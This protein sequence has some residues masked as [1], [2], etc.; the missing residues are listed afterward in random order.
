M[1]GM[2]EVNISVQLFVHGFVSCEHPRRTGFATPSETFKYFCNQQNVSNGVANPVTLRMAYVF[3]KDIIL[4]RSRI[5][6]EK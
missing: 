1:I 4:H 6:V 5:C 3:P 2:C